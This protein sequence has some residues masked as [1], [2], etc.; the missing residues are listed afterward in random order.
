MNYSLTFAMCSTVIVQGCEKSFGKQT[1]VIPDMMPVMHN[2]HNLI[3]I[4]QRNREVICPLS[5]CITCY[6]LM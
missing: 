5:W 4:L 2:F 3:T 1:K 6:R